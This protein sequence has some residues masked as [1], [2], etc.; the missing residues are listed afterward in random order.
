MLPN[1]VPLDATDPVSNGFR[2]DLVRWRQ[3]VSADWLEALLRQQTVVAAPTSGWLLFEVGCDALVQYQQGHIPGAHYLD[4]QAF[5]QPPFWNRVPN[6]M[7]RRLLQQAGITPGRSVILYGRNLLA[8]ARL[9]HLLL[10]AGVQDVRLLDGGLA[11]WVAG[12]YGLQAGP[13]PAPVLALEGGGCRWDSEFPA[14]PDYLL[15]LSQA[16]AMRARPDAALVSIRTRAEYLGETSGYPYIAQRGE[17]AGALWGHAGRDGDVNSMLN[18]QDALGRMKPA[19]EIAALWCE[20]GIVPEL[21][22]AF[23]CGT[24]WRASL[25]FFYAW[26]MGWEHIS[27]FDGGWFE[28]SADPVNPVVCRAA[29]QA[30]QLCQVQM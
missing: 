6:A 16:K 28:W 4:T 13:A 2:A 17:I 5:E 3:L 7:L 19:N 18:F 12:G 21:H 9:A 26:L 30:G 23:Y 11:A 20:A 14:R 22:V 27:V 29:L 24:G 8:A 10:F 25:A 15:D 1:P